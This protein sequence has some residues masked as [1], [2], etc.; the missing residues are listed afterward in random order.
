MKIFLELPYPP[1]ANVIWRRSKFS[2]YL[3]KEGKDYKAAVADYVSENAF[4]KFGDAPIRV[5]MVLRPRD[6]RKRDI[7]NCL[8][9]SI[10]SLASAGLFDDDFQI[11]ELGIKRGDPI[12]GGLL[13]VMIEK[14][15]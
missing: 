3:S 9:I 11:Q 14:I 13:M 10:D 12:S 1:S 7:D 2:T 8:K 4:P 6:K 15:E 5:A